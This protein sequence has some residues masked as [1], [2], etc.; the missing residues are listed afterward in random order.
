MVKP[1]DLTKILK[2]YKK[3]WVALTVDSRRFVAAGSTLSKVLKIA[4]GRGVVNPTV[5]KPAPVKYPFVG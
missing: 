4:R 3:G 5:F 2:R 1:I